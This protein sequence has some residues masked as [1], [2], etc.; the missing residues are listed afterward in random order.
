MR[1][2]DTLRLS[3]NYLKI[4]LEL[5]GIEL[6][7]EKEL[8]NWGWQ[9]LYDYLHML[10]GLIRQ[11]KFNLTFLGTSGRE[12]RAMKKGVIGKTVKHV[13]KNAE[14]GHVPR[15]HRKRLP[16]AML[17]FEEVGTKEEAEEVVDALDSAMKDLGRYA[18]TV[19]ERLK[20][21]NGQVIRVQRRIEDLKHERSVRRF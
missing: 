3:L 13:S 1:E 20:V 11:A 8:A 5:S 9:E 16:I 4:P 18:E 21:L 14:E 15:A 10:K 2:L 19:N 12:L 6:Y 17:I 7:S